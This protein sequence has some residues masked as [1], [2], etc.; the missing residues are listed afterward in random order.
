M[1][2]VR[3][4]DKTLDIDID[5]LHIQVGLPATC[6][7]VLY[8]SYEISPPFVCTDIR[9]AREPGV[10]DEDAPEGLASPDSPQQSWIVTEP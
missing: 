1:I 7:Y 2:N 5:A 10:K 3:D 6:M 4:M 9:G 8:I